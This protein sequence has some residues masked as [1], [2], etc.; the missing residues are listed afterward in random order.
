MM[1]NMAGIHQASYYENRSYLCSISL[2]SR[3]KRLVNKAYK[4]YLQWWLL[5]IL[6]ITS[7]TISAWAD[8][9]SVRPL[10]ADEFSPASAQAL[11]QQMAQVCSSGAPERWAALVTSNV[12]TLLAK[13][14]AGQRTTVYADYCSATRQVVAALGGQI[15]TGVHTLSI[16]T[17]HTECG[18]KISIWHVHSAAGTPITQ[19]QVANEG[20]RMKINTH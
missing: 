6:S 16:D 8:C 1:H 4:P 18:Q 17:Y 12:Q 5:I 15:S 3:A 14:P 10:R 20:G 13:M 9:T 19:L 2:G 11:L 7:F